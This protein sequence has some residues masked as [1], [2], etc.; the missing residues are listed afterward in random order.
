MEEPPI[1]CVEFRYSLLHSQFVDRRRV[2]HSISQGGLKTLLL[3]TL[4][5][6]ALLLLLSTLTKFF[7]QSIPGSSTWWTSFSFFVVCVLKRVQ[8]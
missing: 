7:T 2:T 4:S 1:Y 3:L 5:L 8:H 6:E